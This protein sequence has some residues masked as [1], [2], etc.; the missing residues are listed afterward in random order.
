M[1]LYFYGFREKPFNLT[2]DPR[3]VFL[4]KTHKEAF[5][6]LLHGIHQHVGFIGL[7]GEVGSGKT[8]VLRALLGQLDADHHRTALIFNPCLS[9]PELLQNINREFGITASPS[10]SGSLEALNLFLL[11]QNTEGRTVVLIIDEAQNL[12]APVLEQIRL[13]SNLE[14]DREKLIQ[15]V[16]SG[17]PELVQILKRNEMRQLSQRIVVRYHLQPMDFQDTVRYI[18]HR[19][20]VAGGRDGFI[21]SRGALK[22]IYRYSQG[23]PRLIN[24]ACDRALIAG[25]S[26]DAARVNARIA[27][28]GVKDLRKNKTASSRKKR[29]VL[30]PIF[31][32]LVAVIAMGA[33]LTRLDFSNPLGA[34]SVKVPGEQPRKDR[35]I[36][37]EEFSRA[38]AAQLGGLS[39]PESARRAFNALAGIWNVPPVPENLDLDPFNGI[40]SAALV[41]GLRPYR[42]SGNLGALLRVDYPA[43]LEL[44]LPGVP[45]KRFV[46]LVGME[47]EQLLIDPPIEGRKSLSFSEIEK[48]W[49]GQAVFL[50][51]DSL[52]LLKSA[53]SGSKGDRVKEVQGLLKEAGAYN[54]PLTGIYNA[55]T[56]SAVKEFQASRGI[57]QDGIAGGQTLMFLYREVDRFQ[58]PRLTKGR[59]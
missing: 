58:V 24:A 19:L 26:K 20:E 12:E 25:Y 32:M 46:S 5:A 17:Q 54:K 13:I 47:D 40:E 18:N 9:A 39:E 49:S 22:R 43:A 7:T 15:I 41:R 50:W 42:F 53:S 16:L 1:Y 38:M 45:G 52:N 37:G 14:T 55:D 36:T 23:L 21:F 11:Q 6:H 30:I 3:F 34:P 8:T 4:S 31:G 35:V 56:L 29:L 2:P 59:K 48:Y 57:E 28:A 51:K 27:A 10:S 44:S 33:Y